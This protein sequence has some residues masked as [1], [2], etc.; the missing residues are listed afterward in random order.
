MA[1][2]A[3]STES[4]L[5][6]ELSAGL[7]APAFDGLWA[8]S[9]VRREAFDDLCLDAVTEKAFNLGEKGSLIDA[10]Q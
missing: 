9:R 10:H 5:V 2:L 7:G 4:G 3:V 1:E 8:D 6:G